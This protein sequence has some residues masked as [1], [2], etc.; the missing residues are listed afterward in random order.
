MNVIITKKTY[1]HIKSFFLYPRQFINNLFVFL[2]YNR[3]WNNENLN[4]KKLLDIIKRINQLTRYLCFLSYKSS[5]N[6]C[7]FYKSNIKYLFTSCITN[8]CIY[9]SLVSRHSFD[10]SIFIHVKYSSHQLLEE[11]MSKNRCP[12]FFFADVVVVVACM[13]L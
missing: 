10:C 2:L 5:S 4:G 1:V 8:E 12:S 7:N 9:F 6:C 13:C 11:K 3:M